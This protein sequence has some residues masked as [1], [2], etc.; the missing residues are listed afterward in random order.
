MEEDGGKGHIPSEEELITKRNHAQAEEELQQRGGGFQRASL[1]CI[2][3]NSYANPNRP[4]WQPIG[5]HVSPVKQVHEKQSNQ[6][7]R[8]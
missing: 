2:L 6:P 4:N 8:P 1:L 7:G 5:P 3:V